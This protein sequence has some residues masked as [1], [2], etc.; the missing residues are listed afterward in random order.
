VTSTDL[1]D[2]CAVIA[3][4]ASAL[5]DDSPDAARTA[6]EGV[7]R[8][9]D[10]RSAVLRDTGGAGAIVAVAG[11]VVHAV[12][13]RRDGAGPPPEP[14]VELPV[15]GVDAALTVVGALPTH[16]PLLRAFCWVLGL[17]LGR[18]A[19]ASADSLALLDAA[20]GD[21]QS[22]AD[23]LHDGPVQELVYARFAADA[24]TRGGDPASARDA[25][26]SALQSLRRAL[27]QLRPRGAG[28]GGLGA[29][30]AQLSERLVDSGRPALVLDVDDDAAA[31]LGPHAASVCYRLAQ[32]AVRGSAGAVAVRA[33]R[34]E[35]GVLLEVEGDAPVDE[36][37]WAPRARA[38][39]A[40]L[41]VAP[42]GCARLTVPVSP[43]ISRSSSPTPIEAP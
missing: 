3:A 2:P 26:Q 29:A 35:R 11:D 19:L 32:A 17:A 21:A 38:L 16:L 31:A 37:R 15:P 41:A 36:A 28:D 42:S 5:A 25:V 6:L 39:G 22:A 18:R 7:V 20:D 13:A 4:A 34:V 14:V 43:P 12:P 24:A 33:R 9:L 10:L 27:W 23:D 30:L 40:T 1:A 8:A